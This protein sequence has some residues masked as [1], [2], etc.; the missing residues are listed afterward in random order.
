MSKKN[1]KSPCVDICKID[2]ES[3]Y[4]TGCLRSKHE[5][6]IWKTLSK[7]QRRSL[8]ESISLRTL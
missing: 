8:I 2:K 6:K 1:P 3:G 4:C 5:I 7:S